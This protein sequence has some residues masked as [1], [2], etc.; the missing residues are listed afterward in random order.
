MNADLFVPIFLFG[1]IALVSYKFIEARNKER[2]AMIEKGISAE[3]LNPGG[4]RRP[5]SHP[6]STLKWG[7]LALFIGVGIFVGN[8]L[9]QVLM[10][11]EEAAFFGSVFL[12]GGIALVLHYFIAAKKEKNP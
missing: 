2:M 11:E 3:L 5:Q 9:T 12:A 8:Y 10:M 6:L 4:N 7:L 1:A